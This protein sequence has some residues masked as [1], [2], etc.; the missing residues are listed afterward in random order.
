MA[1]YEAAPEGGIREAGT[2]APAEQPAAAVSSDEAQK[3]EGGQDGAA[4]GSEAENA[5]GDNASE[6]SETS[7]ESS[8][9]EESGE[10]ETSDSEEK[11]E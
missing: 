5:G 6:E 2:A 3:T 10:G 8:D 1:D 4:E 11:S 9:T 7:E